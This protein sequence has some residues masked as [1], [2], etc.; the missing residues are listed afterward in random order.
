[1]F[2]CVFYPGCRLC[3]SYRPNKPA[4][5][6]VWKQMSQSVDKSFSA[7][8]LCHGHERSFALIVSY[9][10]GTLFCIFSFYCSFSCFDSYHQTLVEWLCVLNFLHLTTSFFTKIVTTF[11][12]LED[13]SRDH[14]RLR[15][16]QHLKLILLKSI[17]MV[18]QFK[19]DQIFNQN[20][21][22]DSIP[23]S[24]S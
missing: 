22:N 10:N 14:L 16:Q 1:M 23:K 11:S 4:A 9:I 17:T 3:Y 2:D 19:V 8:L 15:L 12:F 13:N 24:G 5:L 21:T 7:F 6:Y 20:L 18:E